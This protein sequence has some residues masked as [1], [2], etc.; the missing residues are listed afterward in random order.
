MDNIFS[1]FRL[2]KTTLEKLKLLKRAYE[3]TL[4]Q[5]L[6]NDFFM[7]KLIECIK[8]NNPKVWSTFTALLAIKEDAAKPDVEG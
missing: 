5:P 3:L 2:K 1:A 8:V 7:E 6:S 4:V